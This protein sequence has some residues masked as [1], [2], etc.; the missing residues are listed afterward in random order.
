[1]VREQRDPAFWQ[2]VAQHA[3]VAPHV[4]LG[5][6][7]IDIGPRIA[8]PRV[9]PLASENGGYPFVMLDQ[10]GCV[11][12]LHAI[13][14]PEGWGREAH[15]ALKQALRLMFAGRAQVITAYEVQGWWRSRP[16]KSFGFKRAADYTAAP[17]VG[18]AFSVWI[19]TKAA[20]EASPASQRG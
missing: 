2:G 6:D 11:W 1:M 5:R 20:W 19:L 13:Y 4:F 12:D 16:P 17:E 14:R 18:A 9:L 3:D 8:D 15:G 7:P 10:V